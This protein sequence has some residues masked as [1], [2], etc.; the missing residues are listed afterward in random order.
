MINKIKVSRTA[1]ISS[2]MVRVL[3]NNRTAKMTRRKMAS[4]T[5][6]INSSNHQTVSKMLIKT[7]NSLTS[8]MLRKSS[9]NRHNSLKKAS[10]KLA[11]V[12]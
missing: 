8:K 9:N 3:I 11:K 1:R 5:V 6:R 4:K 10:R 2:K 7:V 12:K